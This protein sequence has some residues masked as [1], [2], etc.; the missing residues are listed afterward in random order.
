MAKSLKT[1]KKSPQP[2]AAGDRLRLN[3]GTIATVAAVRGP[4][5]DPDG[6]YLVAEVSYG[7][8][9]ARRWLRLRATSS[10][11]L[12]LGQDHVELIHRFHIDD[13]GQ[14]SLV[15]PAGSPAN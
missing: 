8:G 15:P 13:A 6:G 12:R 9:R 1:A 3:G 7:A 5:E 4:F 14:Y 2:V 11:D 10:G